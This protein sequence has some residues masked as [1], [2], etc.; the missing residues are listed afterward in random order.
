MQVGK[1]EG[2][3]AWDFPNKFPRWGWGRWAK[4]LINED[5]IKKKKDMLN[6]Y[7]REAGSSLV[8][9]WLELCAFTAKGMGS[10]PGQGTN[11]I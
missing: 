2:C 10:I 9:Q 6:M 8:V 4:P 5:V 7:E 3:E 1:G 11:V